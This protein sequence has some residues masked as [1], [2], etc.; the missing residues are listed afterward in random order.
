[1]AGQGVGDLAGEVVE[2]GSG[3]TNS[4]P[5]DEVI[6][7]SFPSSG[8]LAE[9]AVVLASLA[10]KRPS[11]VFVVVGACLSTAAR[12]ALQLLK[13]TGV[14]FDGTSRATGP[15]NALVTAASGGVGHYAV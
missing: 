9:Y 7:I 11:E 5:G 15:K 10:V 1:M 8:G 2:L 12:S 13:L 14:S 3:V 6:S 4:K